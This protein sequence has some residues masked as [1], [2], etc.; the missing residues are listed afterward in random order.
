[1]FT[2]DGTALNFVN[3]LKY[4]GNKITNDLRDDDDDIERE[5]KC[6]SVR[7]NILISRFKLCTRQVKMKLIQS[8]CLCFYGC[9]IR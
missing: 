5:I 9:H 3:N 8:C 6:M 2:A 4:L 7:C 1:V